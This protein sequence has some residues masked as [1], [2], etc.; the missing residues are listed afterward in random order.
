MTLGPQSEDRVTDTPSGNSPRGGGFHS[1]WA[2]LAWAQ[3]VT[4]ARLVGSCPT[5]ECLGKS[6]CVYEL[7]EVLYSSAHLGPQ[8]HPLEI[9]QT[10]RNIER[11]HDLFLTTDTW[12]VY[13][14]VRGNTEA[15]EVSRR[16][17][18]HKETLANFLPRSHQPRR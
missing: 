18:V 2:T 15:N 13:S 1:H 12:Q 5:Y 16:G 4:G 11:E 7:K 17:S 9:F 3:Y 6:A 14:R 10:E 8:H